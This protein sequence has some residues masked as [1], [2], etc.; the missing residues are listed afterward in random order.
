MT[1]WLAIKQGFI[2]NTWW[3]RLLFAG[4][5]LPA[6]LFYTLCNYL[7]SQLGRYIVWQ[8]PVDSWI[9]FSRWFI[10]PYFSW[11]LQI[12]ITVAWLVFSPHTGRL[13]HRMVIAMDIAVLIA[14]VFYLAMPTM[15]IR[16]EVA[17]TDILSQMIRRI[18]EIDLPFNCFPSMH[19]FWATIIAR[20]LALVGPR[21]TWFRLLNYGSLL[22][23]ILS[24]VF[25]KQ[26]YTPDILGGLAVAWISC[27]LSDRLFSESSRLPG[28]EEPEVP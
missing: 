9:P 14:A 22:L 6:G 11:Y 7:A 20:F 27:L 1:V 3:S 2:H 12:G 19:V 18:Y 17:G 25:T 26:H 28:R 5:I 23:I 10:L 21:K 13:L 15:M 16:P 8:L 24:T 4:L